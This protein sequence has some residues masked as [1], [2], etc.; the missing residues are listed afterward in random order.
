[1]NLTT[2][3]KPAR[4][5]VTRTRRI[6][7]KQARYKDDVLLPPVF[8]EQDESVEIWVVETSYNGNT[9]RHEFANKQDADRYYRGFN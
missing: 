5:T 3:T 7:V 9:E 2:A 8:N 6:C 4:E 1:M